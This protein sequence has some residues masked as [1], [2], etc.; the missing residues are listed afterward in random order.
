MIKQERLLDFFLIPQPSEEPIVDFYEFFLPCDFRAILEIEERSKR[1][2]ENLGP[3]IEEI[4]KRKDFFRKTLTFSQYPR[5]LTA[6]QINQLRKKGEE[7][8]EEEL[9]RL[10][11]AIAFTAAVFENWQTEKRGENFQ[12]RDNQ[13][14]FVLLNVLSGGVYPFGKINSGNRMIEL[15]TGEGKTYAT[16][17]SAAVLSIFMGERVWVI[18]PNYGSVLSHAQ[19]LAEFFELMGIRIGALV[20]LP[21]KEQAHGFLIIEEKNGKQVFIPLTP[22]QSQQYV[23]FKGELFPCE[24]QE[25]RREIYNLWVIYSDSASIAFDWLK[26]RLIGQ[27]KPSGQPPLSEITAIL[28]E[29]DTTLVN[30]AV[31]PYV[32]SEQI[33]MKEFWEEMVKEL[34]IDSLFKNPEKVPPS[35][36]RFI[37]KL[38]FFSVFDA[39]FSYQELLSL[40]IRPNLK[41]FD[42]SSQ[43]L[44]FV[45]KLVEARINTLNYPEI[46]INK[47]TSILLKNQQIIIACLYAIFG[48]E[49]GKKYIEERNLAVVLDF[50]GYPALKH[51]YEDLINIFL[52]MKI[53]WQEWKEQALQTLK[54]SKKNQKK[55]FSLYPSLEEGEFTPRFVLLEMVRNYGNSFCLT[56]NL[57]EVFPAVFFQMFKRILGNSGSILPSSPL[58]KTIY[59]AE[60]YIVS[61]HQPPKTESPDPDCQISL[62]CLDKGIA[63]IKVAKSREEFFQWL[64]KKISFS[65]PNSFLIIFPDIISAQNFF[66]ALPDKLK[67]SAIV[68]TGEEEA[69]EPGILVKRTQSVPPNSIIITSPVALR[70]IDPKPTEELIQSGILEVIVVDLPPTIKD[71]FQGLQR[72]GRGD[73]PGKRTWALCL[74]NLLPL[75][76]SSQQKIVEK[77]IS[78]ENEIST[79]Q[80]RRIVDKIFN[81]LY[82]LEKRDG[83]YIKNKIRIEK[84]ILALK[85]IIAP[86][87]LK[88]FESRRAQKEWQKISS[89]YRLNPFLLRKLLTA[90]KKRNISQL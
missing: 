86:M 20:D 54:K 21:N 71:L 83:D 39:I 74:E 34:E 85:R 73:I 89:F 19:Q 48:L 9:E 29:A 17:I 36:K 35:K 7:T 44:E 66:Q 78:Q 27:Q 40:R 72:V 79:D 55:D 4:K 82:E 57:D 61:R 42:L 69:K 51:Q 31:L 75:L 33:S 49:Y 65:S 2:E 22:A 30:N 41:S 6:L 53:H 10:K 50:Y 43:A 14:I 77:I 28:C 62:R 59:D 3:L 38:L 47:L 24:F 1:L 63:G 37:A 15:P 60:T 58:L 25:Q 23:S 64:I 70:D 81:L 84:L 16:A 11:N 8:K 12:L 80:A 67:D 18:E 46:N 76:P 13:F 90:L 68:I 88:K 87:L 32:I 52:Q 45:M 56:E 5:T 26:D